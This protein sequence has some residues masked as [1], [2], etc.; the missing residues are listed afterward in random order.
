MTKL[1]TCFFAY[2][3]QPPLLAETIENGIK[4]INEGNVV[5]LES[6]K[7]ASVSGKFVIQEICKRIDGHDFFACDITCLN[8]NV[9]FELG[10]AI[11]RD[12]R[13]WITR[14]TSVDE[15]NK[16]YKRLELLT[17]VG[18]APY[19]NAQSLGVA[20]YNDRPYED[21]NSTIYKTVIEGIA[22]DTKPQKLLYLKSCY[23]SEASVKITRRIDKSTIPFV[24]ADPIEVQTHT[25]NWYIENVLF[26]C[27][28]L[29]HL[30]APHREGWQLHNAKY[31]LI[32]GLAYG[33]G[34]PLLMLAEKPY[35][36]PIDYKD[37]LR[38]YETARQSESYTSIW[39]SEAELSYKEKKQEFQD[40]GTEVRKKFELR[41]ISIGEYTAE[42]ESD[43]LLFYFVETAAY[44]E[45]LDSHQSIFVGRK[46]SGKTANL[47]KLI[48]ELH[49]DKRNHVCVIKP[50]EY[51]LE[52]VMRML[53]QSLPKSERGYLIESFW[54]FLVYTELAKSLF[55]DLREKPAYYTFTKEEKDLFD[56]VQDNSS[57]ID[58]DFTV[59]LEYGVTSLCGVDFV[60]GASQQR[61]RISEILHDKI[62]GRVRLLLG[63]IL[64]K[65]NR[66]VILVDNLDKTWKKRDD[67]K[68]LTHLLFGL[69]RV[70]RTIRE[71]FEKPILRGKKVNLHLTLFI[72]SDIFDFIIR[73]ARER[74]KINYSLL[75]WDNNE[76]LLRVIEER[77]SSNVDDLATP[78]DMWVRYFCST[79]RGKA[80]VDYILEKIIPRPR[81]IIYFCKAV[82]GEA[83]N[84]GHSI[85]EESD[86]LSGEKKYSKYVFDSLLVEN[87]IRV[88]QLESI[89]YEFIGAKNTL[90]HSEVVE[91]LKKAK[92]E[93]DKIDYVKNVLL[94]LTFLGLEISDN[95]FAFLY[96]ESC[97]D[98]YRTLAR[99]LVESKGTKEPRYEINKPFHAF[100][101]IKICSNVAELV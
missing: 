94:E 62:I 90:S 44:K 27:G 21:L 67:L 8:P 14:D 80:T 48:S 60:S 84:C 5:V 77:F 97:R 95:N 55:D 31:A 17:T 69:L 40:H 83:I 81:D 46:G 4:Q 25:F 50:V 57:L 33:F 63:N 1:P 7:S 11:A 89:L 92:V 59:R 52:G 29:S 43:E 36:S 86:V 2:P 101:E 10:Y 75:T 9:L 87:G 54:K 47:Y 28:V 12:K 98:K 45:A 22:R 58:N 74:D 72:R 42:N 68:D 19:T 26:S 23:N 38:I 88:E 93:E 35:Q 100:L 24:T 41:N 61:A 65:N 91:I 39:L 73:E 15:S 49:T 53:Q 85:V 82:I 70:V 16:N 78:K 76:L 34:K 32:S 13:I 51:E 66:V 96:D 64:S 30:I 20:F 37:L 99:K 6:W 79:V 71:E 18:Y 3:S 56:F